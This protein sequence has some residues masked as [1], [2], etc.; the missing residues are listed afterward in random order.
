MKLPEWL[1]FKHEY[2]NSTILVSKNG[3]M[4]FYPVVED[5]QLDYKL[6]KEEFLSLRKA[7]D[8]IDTMSESGNYPDKEQIDYLT[9]AREDQ[10][11]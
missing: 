4:V 2:K 9:S 7:K 3:Y 11:G 6:S 10:P 5:G 8:F 1:R